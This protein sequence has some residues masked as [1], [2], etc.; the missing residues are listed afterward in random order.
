MKHITRFY[1]NNKLK[2][3]KF[4]I[5]I[6]LYIKTHIHL[7]MFCCIFGKVLIQF[8]HG[9]LLNSINTCLGVALFF[10]PL[11]ENHC[12]Q[13][14]FSARFLILTWSKNYHPYSPAA[15]SI[16]LPFFKITW[17]R[18]FLMIVLST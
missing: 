13:S 4:Q 16:V 11:S 7:N 17:V 6:F 18:E 15:D 8:C 3:L 5:E 10:Q 14:Q 9:S 12:K 2:L 1:N